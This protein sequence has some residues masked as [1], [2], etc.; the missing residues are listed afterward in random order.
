MA[1]D[2]LGIFAFVSFRF[3]TFLLFSGFLGIPFAAA[4]FLSCSTP[5]DGLVSFLE[6]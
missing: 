1:W 6:E 4:A 2:G 3:C 5:E